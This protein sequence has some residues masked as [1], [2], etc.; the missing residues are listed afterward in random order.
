M[1]KNIW[2]MCNGCVLSGLVFL[3]EMKFPDC[4]SCSHPVNNPQ[5]TFK[6]PAQVSQYLSDNGCWQHLHLQLYDFCSKSLILLF[7]YLGFSWLILILKFL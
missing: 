3:L 7:V 5:N 2:D 6:S 4:A 1:S